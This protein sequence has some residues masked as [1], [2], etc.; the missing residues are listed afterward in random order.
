[1]PIRLPGGGE[2]DPERGSSQEGGVCSYTQVEEAVDFP[3]KD[4]DLSGEVQTEE[5]DRQSEDSMGRLERQGLC[6]LRGADS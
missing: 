1:M 2:P 6:W 5:T 4:V 3:S